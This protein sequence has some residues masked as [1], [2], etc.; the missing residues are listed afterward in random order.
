MEINK[1]LRLKEELNQKY[2]EATPNKYYIL[3]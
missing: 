1:K 2:F 3:I